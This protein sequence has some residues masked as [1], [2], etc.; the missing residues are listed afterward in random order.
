[1]S[2]GTSG[3]ADPALHPFL[4]NATEM[5]ARLGAYPRGTVTAIYVTSDGDAEGLPT[6][7]KDAMLRVK[8]TQKLQVQTGQ[9]CVRIMRRRCD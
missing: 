2:G 7:D 5:A 1:M 4:N 9:K 8:K 6:S 3:S